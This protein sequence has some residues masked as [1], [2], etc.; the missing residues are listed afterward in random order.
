MLF[1]SE[2]GDFAPL[3]EQIPTFV[4]VARGEHSRT[5]PF[6]VKTDSK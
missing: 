1:F 4:L 3:R 2:L 6:V 5:M